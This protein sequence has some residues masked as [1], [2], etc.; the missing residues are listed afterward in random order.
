M[1]MCFVYVFVEGGGGVAFRINGAGRRLCAFKSQK[2]SPA[3][4]VSFDH[5]AAKDSA[6]QIWGLTSQ[7]FMKPRAVDTPLCDSDASLDAALEC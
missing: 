3:G 1:T 6:G 7:R 4:H 5:A 2:G